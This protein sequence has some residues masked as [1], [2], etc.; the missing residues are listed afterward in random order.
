M[1]GAPD[2]RQN[3]GV[4]RRRRPPAAELQA[5]AAAAMIDAAD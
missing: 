3:T 5:M 2:V 4:T 1:E